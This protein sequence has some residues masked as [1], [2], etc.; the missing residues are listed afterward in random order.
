MEARSHT[1]LAVVILFC[2][3]PKFGQVVSLNK[4]N[5]VS[6]ID[7]EKPMVTIVVHIYEDVSIHFNLYYIAK[8]I[9]AV[10]MI[11]CGLGNGF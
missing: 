6:S 1:H 7:Q 8:Y 2:C 11:Y 3:S 10:K 4:E 5:F 9:P